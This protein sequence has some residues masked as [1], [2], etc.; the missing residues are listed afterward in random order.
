MATTHDAPTSMTTRNRGRKLPMTVISTLSGVRPQKDAAHPPKYM[1]EG[2][3]LRKKKA[4]FLRCFALSMFNITSACYLCSMLPKMFLSTVAFE[5]CFNIKNNSIY[6]S[7][8]QLGVA[9]APFV[10][11]CTYSAGRDPRTRGRC[12]FVYHLTSKKNVNGNLSCA[13]SHQAQHYLQHTR[14]FLPRISHVLYTVQY[15]YIWQK[16]YAAMSDR[17]SHNRFGDGSTLHG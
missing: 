2:A 14:C 9:V 6:W 15:T 5:K 8:V 12:L 4:N 13:V 16:G 3:L 17:P 1:R 10:L 11:E 7:S